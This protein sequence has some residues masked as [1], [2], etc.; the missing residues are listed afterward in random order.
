MKIVLK[1]KMLITTGHSHAI[2]E[3]NSQESK[4][5][6]NSK[7]YF[8]FKNNTLTKISKNEFMLYNKDKEW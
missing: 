4:Y 1:G 2:F 7:L 3:V 8:L 5:S 6:E